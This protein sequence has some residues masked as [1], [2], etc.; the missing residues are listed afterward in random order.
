MVIQLKQ[1]FRLNSFLNLSSVN[2]RFKIEKEIDNWWFTQIRKK[3]LMTVCYDIIGHG[4]ATDVA[5]YGTRYT[6]PSK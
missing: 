1:T 4:Q 6:F 5:Y 3:E 2:L